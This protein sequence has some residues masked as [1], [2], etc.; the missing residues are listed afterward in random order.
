MPPRKQMIG[1]RSGLGTNQPTRCA[2]KDVTSSAVVHCGGSEGGI[3]EQM[4]AGVRIVTSTYK[5]KE[6]RMGTKKNRD[7]LRR[8]RSAE[9][10]AKK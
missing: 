9:C 1:N 7:K 3:T 10:E 4:G 6:L 5:R 8:G 2:T